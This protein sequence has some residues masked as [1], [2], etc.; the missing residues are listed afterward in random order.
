[1]IAE[2][3]RR[4]LDD[5]DKL[6]EL[7]ESYGFANVVNHNDKYISFGRDSASRKDAIVLWLTENTYLNIKDFGRNI[8]KDLLGYITE[9]R[10]VSFYEVITN[11]KSLL[12]IS[13]NDYIYKEKRL[14]FGGF[15]SNINSKAQERI[16]I[17][18]EIELEIYEQTS[19]LRFLRDGISLATQKEFGL[20]YDID[21]ESIIIPIRSPEGALMGV[22]AR[23]NYEADDMKYWYPL[24]CRNSQTLYGYS[25]NYQYLTNGV[26][27]IG[28]AEKFVMQAHS[29]GVRN[30]V[31]LG[32]GSI[33]E[34]QVKLIYELQPKQII[35]M[36]DVGY[37][38]DAVFENIKKLKGYS[39]LQDTKVSYW[40][41]FN[42]N[43]KDKASATDLG[44]GEFL[45]ILNEE[46]A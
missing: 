21:S 30:A 36:H 5:P 3:K 43:Y 38:K 9:Q 20:R 1:M 17:Y 35:L 10:K 37:N 19:N 8:H 13:D 12:G 24:P 33:S 45:R 15:Y 22:K 29:F 26:V 46:I 39:R 40:N 18:D 4:L 11:A 14:P 44:K 31:A 41:Y 25:T 27:I 6:M 28:E 7:L 23:K 34:K 16:K 32:S 2:I 42:K